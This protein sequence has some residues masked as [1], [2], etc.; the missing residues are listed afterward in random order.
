F[1]G[2]PAAGVT[3]QTVLD[4]DYGAIRRSLWLATDAAYKQ[5][6][7]QLARKRAFVQ[8]KTRS[9]QIPDFSKEQPVTAVVSRRNLDIDKQRWEKQVREWSALFKDFP[10]I[11]ESSVVLEAQ[12]THRYLVNSEGTSTLQDRKSVV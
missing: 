1:Q 7:E 5:A 6:V 4:N 9:E 3:S 2:A 12:L 8:N 11:E 10:E